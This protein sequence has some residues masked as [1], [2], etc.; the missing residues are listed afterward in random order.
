VKSEIQIPIPQ[1]VSTGDPISARWANQLRDCVQRLAMRNQPRERKQSAYVHPWKAYSYGDDTV[2]V[3]YGSLLAY[4]GASATD[5]SLTMREF[6]YFEGFEPESYTPITVTGAGSLYGAISAGL[7][8]YPDINFAGTTSPSGDSFTV[9]LFR[10]FPDSAQDIIFSFETTVPIDP[11]YFYFEI[12]KVDLD[13]GVA[14]I[15]RQILTH[16]P[17]MASWIEGP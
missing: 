11:A 6:K 1:R 12:A 9:D 16:N 3:G 2:G 13:G 14:F 7:A 15:D 4:E 5:G 10:V 8:S 17:L